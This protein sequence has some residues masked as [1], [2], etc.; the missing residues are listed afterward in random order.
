MG[1]RNIFF[2]FIATNDIIIT[3]SSICKIYIS[4]ILLALIKMYINR[5]G[6]VTKIKNKL[7]II[8]Y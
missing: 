1:S 7:F 8:I 2:V 4:D 3:I 6:Y 5:G